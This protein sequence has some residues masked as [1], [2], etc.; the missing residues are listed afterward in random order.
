[1]TPQSPPASGS[2]E[3][4]WSRRF[5]AFEWLR[6]LALDGSPE[7]AC[8][9][10]EWARLG[11]IAS[12]ARKLES[13]LHSNAGATAD[14]PVSITADCPESATRLVALLQDLRSALH[15]DPRPGPAAAP[16]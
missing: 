14:W 1:V 16:G 7:A 12:A 13:F 6:G 11:A 5:A 8:A 3:G 9:L 4:R 2:G 15:D 10:E